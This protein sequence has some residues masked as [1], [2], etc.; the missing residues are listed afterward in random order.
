MSNFVECSVPEV[1]YLRGEKVKNNAVNLDLCKFLRKTRYSWYPDNVGLP[2]I[3]FEGCDT[4]WVFKE[5]TAR[6]VEHAR[7]ANNC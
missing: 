3:K 6:D 5:E 4:E 2:S 7:L 1:E